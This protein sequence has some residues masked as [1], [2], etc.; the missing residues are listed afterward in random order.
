MKGLLQI[1][2]R[3]T[4]A[5]DQGKIETHDRRRSLSCSNADGRRR[6]KAVA[7]PGFAF[8]TP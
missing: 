4:H 3:G 1:T 2:W 5:D 8:L 6:I 7:E